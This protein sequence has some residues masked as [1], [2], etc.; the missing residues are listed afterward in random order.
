MLERRMFPS[1]KTLFYLQCYT[2][3]PKTSGFKKKVY[4]MHKSVCSILIGK[5]DQTSGFSGV[6]I[7]IKI[8]TK[9]RGYIH[10]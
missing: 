2:A 4:F 3:M 5:L 6:T 7:C 9:T 1:F 10:E 8:L